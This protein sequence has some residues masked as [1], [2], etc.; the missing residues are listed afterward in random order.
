MKSLRCSIRF[1]RGFT[2]IELLVVIAIIAILAAMLMP[3]LS[4]AKQKAQGI[5]CL[6][7]GKQLSLSFQMYTLD[8]TDFFPPNPDDGTVQDGHNWCAGNAGGGMPG[9]TPGGAAFD[10]DI[11]RDPTKTL[12][13]A[14]LGK[15]VGVFKCPADPRSGLFNGKTVPAARSVAMNQAVGTVCPSYKANAGHGGKPTL[16]T[17]GPWLTGA[18]NNSPNIYATFGKSS[19]FRTIGASMVFLTVDESP[20]SINDGGFAVSVGTPK[21]VD[22]PATFHNRACGFSFADGHAEIRRW[23]GNSM[24]LSAPPGGQP[25]TLPTDP[26]WNWIAQHTSARR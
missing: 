4:K 3:A 22:F 1:A 17:N 20:W 15:N 26:D 10:T 14:Y 21:W 25:S 5:H 23:I 2:L 11:L 19:D 12:V 7:N 24:S 9:A 16:P 6:N 13:A 8:F 18:R